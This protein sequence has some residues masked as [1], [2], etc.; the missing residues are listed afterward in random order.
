MPVSISSHPGK[1]EDQ[2]YT[3]AYRFKIPAF[4]PTPKKP[5]KSSVRL[6]VPAKTPSPLLPKQQEQK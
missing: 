5:T 4:E 6:K 2:N 3:E 1:N